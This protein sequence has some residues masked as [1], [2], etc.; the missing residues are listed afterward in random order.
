[1][2]LGQQLPRDSADGSP[3]MAQMVCL[4][5]VCL[6]YM[7]G[8]L[9]QIHG[10]PSLIHRYLLREGRLQMLAFAVIRLRFVYDCHRVPGNLEELEDQSKTILLVDTY[11]IWEN[12]GSILDQFCISA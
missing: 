4:C 3:R 10:Y 9:L 2:L 1:M 11:A 6:V 12:F 5:V 8:H 7:E